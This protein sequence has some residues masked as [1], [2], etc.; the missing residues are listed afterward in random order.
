LHEKHADLRIIVGLWAFRG[1]LAP[2]KSRLA[3]TAPGQLVINLRD[4]Q[5]GI[6]QLAR[7]F[8]AAAAAG[9]CAETLAENKTQSS[10]IGSAA[11]LQ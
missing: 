6:D 4:A 5:E 9:A 3:L 10:S 2:T 7:P 8:M 1:D 11:Q